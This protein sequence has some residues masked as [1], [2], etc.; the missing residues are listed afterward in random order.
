[1]NLAALTLEPSHAAGLF[2]LGVDGELLLLDQADLEQLR[3]LLDQVLPRHAH[4]TDE[5]DPDGHVLFTSVC[6]GAQLYRCAAT[7]EG[8]PSKPLIHQGEA[9]CRTCNQLLAQF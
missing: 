6:C 9:S 8:L 1:M 4:N 2:A 5:C 3:S 7:A